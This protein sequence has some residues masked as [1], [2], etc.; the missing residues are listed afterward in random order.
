MNL[1]VK[2]LITSGILI[3]GLGV[4]GL[5]LVN[6]GTPASVFAEAHP[7]IQFTDGAKALGELSCNAKATAVTVSFGRQAE[8]QFTKDGKN[9]GNPFPSPK[10]AKSFATQFR[11]DCKIF[12]FEWWDKKA[13]LMEPGIAIPEGAN[14]FHFTTKGRITEFNW[15]TYLEDGEGWKLDSVDVPRKVKHIDFNC[16]G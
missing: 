8:I 14:D 13:H 2:K 4:V 1:S 11:S 6:V 12:S 7:C 16:G 5:G 3:V 10:G 9:I 15:G